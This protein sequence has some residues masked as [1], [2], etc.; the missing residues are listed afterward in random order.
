MYDFDLLETLLGETGFVN[1][2]RCEYR[3]GR[4]PDLG[5]LDNRPEE[6]LYVEAEKPRRCAGRAMKRGAH[7]RLLRG[8]AC[9][10]A[11]SLTAWQTEGA[12]CARGLARLRR[13]TPLPFPGRAPPW[14][15][16]P[17]LI[18]LMSGGG[19]RSVEGWSVGGRVRPV[20][21]GMGV[22]LASR[23]LSGGAGAEARALPPSRGSG[24]FEIGD[25]RGAR[26][27]EPDRAG[28]P[29]HSQPTAAPR[30]PSQG[31]RRKLASFMTF[32]ARRLIRSR[33]RRRFLW[34]QRVASD[35]QKMASGTSAHP[36][37]DPGRRR[38]RGRRRGA[39]RERRRG[40][41]R[42]PCRSSTSSRALRG[43]TPGG[44]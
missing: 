23:R 6:T 18:G 11:L 38:S 7:L 27:L 8:P 28:E 36:R 12:L 10:A 1:V 41:R 40:A 32:C 30:V 39:T 20:P 5:L 14:G 29:S 31:R 24:R 22:A 26:R 37:C 17:T 13:R 35:V 2:V 16:V 3:Q 34:V 43:P 33:L 42:P 25:G 4:A 19:E 21:G 15:G 44:T 9:A